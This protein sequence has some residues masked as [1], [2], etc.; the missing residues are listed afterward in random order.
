MDH[1]QKKCRECNIK[2][3]CWKDAKHLP[4]IYQKSKAFCID[5]KSQA[6]KLAKENSIV[7]FH[8]SNGWLVL[9]KKK[10]ML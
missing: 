3:G 7:D 9:F 1:K 5:I 6:I 10:N 4:N 8:A 2:Q